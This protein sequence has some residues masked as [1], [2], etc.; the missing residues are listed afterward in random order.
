MGD[1]ENAFLKQEFRAYYKAHPVRA[2]P[3]PG[4]REFGIGDFGKKI[5]KRHMAF[6]GENELNNFLEREAPPFISYSAAYYERPG[7]RPMDRK[8]FIGA[9]LIYEFDADDIPTKCK[10][11]HDS[12]EC[13]NPECG[14]KGKGDVKECPK[15]GSGAKQEQ[16]FCAECLEE[17]KKQ[18]LR[19][20][21]ILSGELGFKEGISVNFSGKAGYHVHV[22]S[23]KA[24]AL[25]RNARNE[26]IDYLTLNGFDLEAHGFGRIFS[27][28]FSKKSAILSCPVPSQS[29]GIAGRF[30][31]RLV[32]FIKE[33]N[34]EKLAVH[35]NLSRKQSSFLLK[36]RDS[37]LAK[38]EEGILFPADAS[39]PE[40]SQNFWKLLIEE[41][42]MEESLALDIDR[43]TSVDVHKILRLPD[44]I[45]G[46]TG[47]LAKRVPLAELRKFEPFR[48]AVALKGGPIKVFINKAP[49]FSLG[50]E[51]F[52]ASVMEEKELPLAAAV[53]LLASGR[54]E[55]R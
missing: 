12:W 2:I 23:E 48:D 15:C 20:I 4:Q 32:S 51:K 27:Q 1:R 19:L 30:M 49:E 18:T 38:M 34:A 53:F 43:Q 8:G 45:H 44:S 25:S 9:D 29:R 17:T 10:E 42:M 41:A 11:R 22:R 39:K 47:L 52:G 46:G 37:I 5:V 36:N 28:G 7:A 50:G 16:W 3:E 54:A 13:R 24:K 40:T 6:A 14:E 55:L 35:G 31:K 26:L 21:E 33:W